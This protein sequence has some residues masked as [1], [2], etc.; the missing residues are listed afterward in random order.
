[1]NKKLIA[2]DNLPQYIKSLEILIANYNGDYLHFPLS[3]FELLH[4]LNNVN[5]A[6]NVESEEDKIC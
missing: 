1:M 5:D 3:A 6:L 4:W 2:I